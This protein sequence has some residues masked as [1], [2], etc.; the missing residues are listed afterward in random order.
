VVVSNADVWSPLG[1]IHLLLY[2]WSTAILHFVVAF[3]AP[4]AVMSAAKA[5]FY[6]KRKIAGRTCLFTL[7]FSISQATIF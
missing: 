2:Y 1:A 3:F 7:L 5:V 4:A 6:D